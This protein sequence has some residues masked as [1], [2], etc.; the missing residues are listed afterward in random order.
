MLDKTQLYR[1][2]KTCSL[3][4]SPQLRT[5]T[6]SWASCILGQPY[7]GLYQKQCGQ[8]VKG[9]DSAPPLRPGENPPGVLRPALEHSA[10]ER[11]GADPE[12]SH[13]NDQRAGAPL[14]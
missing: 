4:I 8:Q 9:G 13:K 6:V 2:L 14:L 1:V 11:H 12:E 7:P 5:P 10:Q 3:D